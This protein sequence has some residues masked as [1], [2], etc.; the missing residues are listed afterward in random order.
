MRFAIGAIAT[1][2]RMPGQ[3]NVIEEGESSNGNTTGMRDNS[4]WFLLSDLR[5]L[6]KL[7][8]SFNV[9]AGSPSF[10][11]EVEKKGEVMRTSV[12]KVENALYG[13]VV[14]EN[15]FVAPDKAIVESGSS[16][17]FN[18]SST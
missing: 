8:D 12:E 11:T 1:G 2:G 9:T 17:S 15:E 16:G 10:R 3:G 13:L 4:T 5:E 6:R 7:L 18:L 14:R